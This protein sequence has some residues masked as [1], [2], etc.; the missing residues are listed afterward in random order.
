MRTAN[1]IFNAIWKE[2]RRKGS[3]TLIIEEAINAGRIEL[4]E[5][6]LDIFPDCIIDV[7]TEAGE[8]YYCDTTL[9][10]KLK[11]QIK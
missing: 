8:G 5:E 9:I 11:E 3:T 2:K 1:E 10:E 4:I 6:I 7:T